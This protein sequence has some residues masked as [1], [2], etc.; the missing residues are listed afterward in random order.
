MANIEGLIGAQ[1]G[2]ILAVG[3]ALIGRVLKNSDVDFKDSVTWYSI[4]GFEIFRDR[5]QD[6]F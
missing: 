2:P 5:S 3:G 1:Q 4:H 6:A